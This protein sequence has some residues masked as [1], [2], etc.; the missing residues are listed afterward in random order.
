[1]HISYIVCITDFCANREAHDMRSCLGKNT[2]FANPVIVSFEALPV[3][4][5]KI[6]PNLFAK[7]STHQQYNVTVKRIYSLT[8]QYIDDV[9]AHHDSDVIGLVLWVRP[10][11]TS[12]QVVE[13]L[14]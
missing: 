9:R 12:T 8:K 14:T 7:M 13:G 4:T 3:Y 5:Y 11:V 6:Q 1:M 10:I 2:E